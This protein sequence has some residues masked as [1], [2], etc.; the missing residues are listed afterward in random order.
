M[1]EIL[2]V[3]IQYIVT[4]DVFRILYEI[5]EIPLAGRVNCSVKRID[6]TEIGDFAA[7][8]GNFDI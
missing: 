1:L 5:K 6:G 8:Y 2:K 4:S 3:V 7:G